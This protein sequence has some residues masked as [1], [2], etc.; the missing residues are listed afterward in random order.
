MRIGYAIPCHRHVDKNIIHELL[1]SLSVSTKLPDE[2][3]I[4]FSG[5]EDIS[6]IKP[7]DYNFPLYITHTSGNNS[8]GK[9]RNIAAEKLNTDLICFFD[10]DDLVHPQRNE[11]L[12]DAFKNDEVK[13]LVHDLYFYHGELSGPEMIENL[14]KDKT[15]TIDKCKN[16]NEFG[17]I[18]KTNLLINYHDTI[19]PNVGQPE[20][21]EKHLNYANGHITIRKEIFEK[22]KYEDISKVEDTQYNLNLLKNGYKF[23]HISDPLMIYRP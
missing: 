17:F 1:D 10:S 16:G 11:I 13:V 19:K 18:E 6:D 4:S 7:T 21:S 9:N 8:T 15:F 22:F 2:V 20:N 5:V 23:S 14:L 3:S 12:L